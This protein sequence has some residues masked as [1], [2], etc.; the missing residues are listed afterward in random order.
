MEIQEK[1]KN[2]SWPNST[3]RTKKDLRKTKKNNEKP[4]NIHENTGKTSEKD[5]V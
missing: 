1:P 3:P 5:P 2:K 4:K